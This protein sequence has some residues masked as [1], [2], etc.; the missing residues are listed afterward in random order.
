MGGSA[1]AYM[2]LSSLLKPLQNGGMQIII[3]LGDMPQVVVGT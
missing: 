1:Y 3:T 2:Y